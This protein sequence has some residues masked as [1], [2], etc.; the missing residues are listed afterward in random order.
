MHYALCI[1]IAV[2]YT[3]G[4]TRGIR[5]MDSVV[6][7]VILLAAWCYLCGIVTSSFSLGDYSA[8]RLGC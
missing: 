1:R 3:W 4:A 2:L 5:V 8:E 7:M 6:L